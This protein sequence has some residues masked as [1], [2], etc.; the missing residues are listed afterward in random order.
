MAKWIKKKITKAKL[1]ACVGLTFWAPINR[2]LKIW[3]S[4]YGREHIYI[5]DSIIDCKK[6]S[7]YLYVTWIPGESSSCYMYH[8]TINI[9]EDMWISFKNLI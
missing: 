7:Y 9:L 3:N 8:E 5:L 6:V 4:S 2:K 1:S